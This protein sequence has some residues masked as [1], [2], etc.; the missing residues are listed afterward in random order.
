MVVG[1]IYF[2]NL[3][4]LASMN[5]DYNF[6]WFRIIEKKWLGIIGF[7]IQVRW[8]LTDSRFIFTFQRNIIKT[9][10]SVRCILAFSFK[11]F[12]FLGI[13]VVRNH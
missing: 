5:S 4:F 6:V 9:H 8:K 10:T 2:G 7:G 1:S 11:F 12:F 3:S 13:V